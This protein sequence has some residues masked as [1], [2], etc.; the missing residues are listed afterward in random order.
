LKDA[1]DVL[2]Y[3][4]RQLSRQYE[5]SKGDLTAQQKAVQQYMDLLARARGSGP[6]DALRWGSALARVSRLTDIPIDELN[7]RFKA[8]PTPRRLEP[9]E[10]AG[11]TDET[12][13]E[14]RRPPAGPRNAQDLAERHLLGALLVEP[15]RWH[16]VQQH[17]A[18]EDFTDDWRRRLA[19][20]YWQVQ[21]DVGEPVF[22]EFLSDIKDPALSEL[23]VELV[24]E[25]DDLDP[26][27]LIEE[28][29]AH[30][31]EVRRRVQEQKLLSALSR[32]KDQRVSE[33]EEVDLLRQLGQKNEP[34]LHRLGPVRRDGR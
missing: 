14:I 25:I 4:W 2:T 26:G 21:R 28:S 1:T 19:E 31:A 33:Q 3:K 9:R 29:L 27:S 11:S 18:A 15:Q 30:L 23:A 13:E 17:I 7:R 6:I 10:T 22:N 8:K 20:L 16:D 24:N 5:T 12:F 34:N 32:T